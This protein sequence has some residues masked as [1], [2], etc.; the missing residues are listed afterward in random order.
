MTKVPVS[1]TFG[2]CRAMSD[3]AFKCLAIESNEMSWPAMAKAKKEPLSWLGMNPVGMVKKRSAHDEGS[4]V[5]HVRILPGNVRYGF[6][7]L[8]HRIKRDVLAGH[9]SSFD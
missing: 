8:G 1:A 6:Q 7:V 2:S 5:R 9:D 3:T 4:G